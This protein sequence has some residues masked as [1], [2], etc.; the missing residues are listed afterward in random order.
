[1][2]A[3]GSSYLLSGPFEP[4]NRLVAWGI[5]FAYALLFHLV[6]TVLRQF[7]N[8]NH[9]IAYFIL[10]IILLPFF[11]GI[12]LNYLFGQLS[13]GTAPIFYGY[14][15]IKNVGITGL[16]PSILIQ[17]GLLAYTTAIL[18]A[19]IAERLYELLARLI[20]PGWL[21]NRLYKVDAT[22]DKKGVRISDSLFMTSNRGLGIGIVALLAHTILILSILS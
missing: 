4:Y 10:S 19:L 11:L 12:M 21:M 9:L 15:I 8:T 2:I 1:M 20:G 13:P 17:Y 7:E 14:G 5:I 3:L 6:W 18:V 16:Y 22:L